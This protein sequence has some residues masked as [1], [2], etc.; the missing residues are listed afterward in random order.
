MSFWVKTSSQLSS[1]SSNPLV[2]SI[3]TLYALVLLYLPSHFTRIVLSP[4]LIITA[5][6]LLSLLR[7]GASQTQRSKP[8][9]DK[10]ADPTAAEE[11][12]W[13]VFN[14]RSD[15]DSDSDSEPGASFEDSFVQWN[16]R[17]PLEVIYEEDEDEDEDEFEGEEAKRGL[18]VER[19]RSL[20]RFYP[21]SDS[22]DSSDGDFAAT[23]FWEEEDHER[24]EGPMIEIALDPKS[25]CDDDEKMM[26]GRFGFQ[27]DEDN[28]IEID[29]SPPSNMV[30]LT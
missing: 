20:S 2:S 7:L 1:I 21:E 25:G 9:N 24:D 29:I 13:V 27:V 22:D 11:D 15:S 17:A 18:G 6:L 8:Q 4:V 23:E 28:L 3:V 30:G 5:A 14:Y 12:E 19:F 10:P 26:I 16:L